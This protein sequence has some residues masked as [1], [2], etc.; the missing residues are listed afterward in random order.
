[1]S[2]LNNY[3]KVITLVNS[4][5]NNVTFGSVPNL[6]ITNS[7][8]SDSELR[9]DLSSGGLLTIFESTITGASLIRLLDVN[10]V[11]NVNV[12]NC[13]LFNTTALCYGRISTSTFAFTNTAFT[14]VTIDTYDIADTLA[15]FSIVDSSLENTTIQNLGVIV[16]PNSTDIA[17]CRF[18]N[19]TLWQQDSANCVL[20]DSNFSNTTITANGGGGGFYINNSIFEYANLD[21]S[22][23]PVTTYIIDDMT[24]IK[25]RGLYKSTFTF[26][27][28]SGLGLVNVPCSALTDMI[29]QDVFKAIITKATISS[30]TGLTAGVGSNISLGNSIVPNDQYISVSLVSTLN[31]NYQIKNEPVGVINNATKYAVT[32]LPTITSITAGS[33]EI[34]V[35][36][37]IAP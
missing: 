37:L 3:A 15:I 10:R 17:R 33:A 7:S 19:C 22:P 1:L 20:Y 13:Q 16:S 12:Y 32:I 25:N 5:L 28:S 4:T 9:S 2:G 24:L 34:A 21:F 27:G 30:I 11:A 6:S 36:F 23:T 29:G 31:A 14:N 26:D 18:F 8:I 35:E